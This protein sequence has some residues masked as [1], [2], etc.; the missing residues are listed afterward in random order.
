MPELLCPVCAHALTFEKSV[1]ACPE[2]HRFDRARSGYVNLLISRQSGSQH[3]DDREMV[4]ARRDFLQTGHYTPLRRALCAAVLRCAPEGAVDLLDAGCGECYYTAAAA[5][6][7][8]AAGR[9]VSAAGVDISKDALR[10]GGKRSAGIALAVASVF[11]LPVADASCDLV[12]NIF[13]PFAGEEYRRVLRRGGVVLQAAPGAGH[14]WEL[15]QAVYDTPYRNDAAAPCAEGLTLASEETLRYAL[16]LNSHQEI[17]DL[18]A[19]TPYVHKTGPSDAAR[20]NALERLSVGAEFILR[21][22]RN[23]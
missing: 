23:E 9:T 20:L 10:F 14:L 13:A 6:T 16:E 1:C 4:R 18:F 22:Y 21:I 15:K 7:L 12:L 11:H 3:G 17:A 8:R 19:M 2:G 5:E